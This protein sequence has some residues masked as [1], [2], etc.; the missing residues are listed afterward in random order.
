M[1]ETDLCSEPIHVIETPIASRG[2]W[3]LAIV[4]CAL[5]A[6][7]LKITL[8]LN[9]YGS[10]DVLFW[11]ANLAK[12]RS[13]GALALYRDGAQIFRDGALYHTE[14]FNQPPFM[15][16]MLRLWGWLA[17]ISGLPLRFWLRCT[18]TLNDLGS[19]V[20]LARILTRLPGVKQHNALLLVA[21][22]P[23]SIM[24]SGFHGNTD[25]VMIFWTL[26][27]MDLL[28]STGP[29]WLAGAAMGMAMSTKIV[30]VILL[31]AAIFYL[32]SVRRRVEF[33]LGAGAIF[34]AC[35]LPVRAQDPRLVLDRVF[36]YN[37]RPGH[38]GFS[39][40]L[41]VITLLTGKA[42]WLYTSYQTVG[43]VVA[44]ALAVAAAIRM[45]L[46]SPKPPP[47]LQWGFLLFLFV[48]LTPG[49]G[50]QYLAWLVPWGAA[51]S[52]RAILFYYAS[53]SLFLFEVYSYWCRGLPWY[54]A[55][56]ISTSDLKGSMLYF[57]LET[58]SWVAVGWVVLAAWRNL[59]LE[60]R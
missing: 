47:F 5:L 10:N 53:S 22:S 49:F 23:V 2:I 25:A 11:E 26:L 32:S 43:K 4:V 36:A 51:L 20:L 31:P 13:D 60:T 24:V 42:P 39:R 37:S 8:A 16:H 48:F 17:D 35:S 50:V 57:S 12:I 14:P 33:L 7:A 59:N 19:L 1:Q 29:A 38:W 55:D 30:P 45:N 15:I 58:L 44:L 40:L 18:S 52:G 54:L 56:M 27:S 41:N 21:L 9:T 3:P 46:Q 6:F 28:E 34:L